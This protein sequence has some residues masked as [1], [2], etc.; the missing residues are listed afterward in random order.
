MGFASSSARLSAALQS[1]T[2]AGL[3]GAIA[4]ILVLAGPAQAVDIIDL[5]VNTSQGVPAPPYTVGTPVTISGVVTVGVGTFTYEYTDVYVQDATAG[6]MVYKAGS[7]PYSFEIGDSVTIEGEIEH[8]R[9]MTEVVYDT[10]TVHATG[11]ALPDPLIVHCEDVENVFQPDYTEPNEGRFVR[12]NNV[13]WTGS[14]PSF[15]GPITLHD[16]TGTCT[17]YI[18]GTT[19]IQDMTPP[20]GPFDVVGVIKQYAGFTP[21]YTSGYEILPRSEEDFFLLPGPQ[22]LDGPRETNI[23]HDNVTIHFETDTPTDATIR[24]GL[25]NSYELGTVTSAATATVHDIVIENL[26]AATIHHYEVTVEDAVG[27]TTTPDKLFCSGSAPGCTGTISCIFNKSVDHS[28]A[29]YSQATGG[30]DLEGWIIDRINATQLTIDVAL[31]SFNLAAVADALIAAK[32]RG[33]QIR[34]VY[35]N[36]ATYQEQVIRL[37]SNGILVI[38][39]SF[40]ANSGNGIMHHKLWT[41]DALSED[42]ADPWV[43][44]GSWN[45]TTQGTHT[46]AQ[47]VIMIQ[48]QALAVVCTAEFNEMW[49]SEVWIPNP[50]LSRFGVNK[51]DNTPHLFNVG[52]RELSLYFAPSDPW[53]G[54]MIDEVEETQFAT[55]FCIMSF[56]RYDLCN[57]IEDRWMT[58]PGFEV[59]G[60]FDSSEGGN[61]YS[62]YH[63]MHGDG[64]YAWNPPADVW[65]DAETG[66]LHHKYMILDVNHTGSDPVLITGSANWSTAA[67]ATND[68]NVLIVHDPSIANQYYQEFAER[69]YAAGGSAP[70]AANIVPIP[71]TRVLLRVGPNPSPFDLWATFS[72]DVGGP[73][74]CHLY[75]PDGRLVGRLLKQVVA[76][77]QHRIRWQPEPGS[78]LASGMYYVRLSTPMGQ[79]SRRV[80]FVR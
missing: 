17:L 2:A 8:Y 70:L 60:A 58:V 11:A 57:E 78:A 21:P 50:D 20:S 1:K 47:N 32:D 26:D 55:H 66:T 31:Y 13:A 72:L 54:A 22:F 52:G 4:W 41:F 44:S 33:V 10:Y 36:R 27:Q 42:P 63:P 56:T 75:A 45:L 39:D 73:V 67:F 25:T 69:Y 38:D 53:L 19:G 15:S 7:P 46:D 12:L 18:D 79:V 64:A 28:L 30:Q 68:E 49:G 76:P 48:D 6:V 3:A 51:D 74:T 34:F 5:H 40:G 37:Q 80:T 29:T 35:D 14:W 61:S 77:G 71:D 43:Y 65:L 24:Y 62:Q 59:R 9:G 16:E 23:Q